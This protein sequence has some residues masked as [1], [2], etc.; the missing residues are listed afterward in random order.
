[1]VSTRQALVQNGRMPSQVVMKGARSGAPEFLTVDNP[2]NQRPIA[3]ENRA[4]DLRIPRFG[5]Q[6]LAGLADVASH[7]GY[8]VEEFEIVDSS[9]NPLSD[10]DQHEVSVI[11]LEALSRGGAEEVIRVLVEDFPS[12]RIEGVDLVTKD[13]DSIVLRRNGVAE[14]QQGASAKQLLSYAWTILHFA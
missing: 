7:S 12:F 10:S 3:F 11:L 6:D 1:M 8:Q 4:D 9:L 14:I 2:E 5:S 13:D